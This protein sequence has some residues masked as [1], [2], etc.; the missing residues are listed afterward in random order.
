LLFALT[1]FGLR[2]SINSPLNDF[3]TLFYFLFSPTY[4]P[5]KNLLSTVQMLAAATAFF[6]AKPDA[7]VC[8][9]AE[10]GNVFGPDHENYAKLHER[11]EK[12][13]YQAFENPN[14]VAVEEVADTVPTDEP[15]TGG[16]LSAEDVA[17]LKGLSNDTDTGS[18]AVVPTSEGAASQPGGDGEG[19]GGAGSELK[20]KNGE[21][22]TEAPKGEEVKGEEVSGPAADAPCCAFGS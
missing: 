11:Q 19:S 21:G 15:G 20:T 17:A 16:G 4:Y 12:V 5:M 3:K 6:G 22:K 8:F 18:A 13:G 1:G 2:G 10:D 7:N 14:V 9:V